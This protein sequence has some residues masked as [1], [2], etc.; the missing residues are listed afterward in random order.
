LSEDVAVPLEALQQLI[1]THADKAQDKLLKLLQSSQ[2]SLTGSGKQ[3]GD[4][5]SHLSELVGKAGKSPMD[6]LH[7]A[8]S[9]YLPYYPLHPP[10]GF[11][12]R[13]EA[14][15]GGQDG[16]S[17]QN[18]DVQLVLWIET[19]RLGPFK[20]TIAP[21]QQGLNNPTPSQSRW[22]VWVEHDPAAVSVLEVLQAQVSQSS[23]G[24]HMVG[25]IFLPRM[26]S[27]SPSSAASSTNHASESNPSPSS[28]KQSVD[29][30]PTGSVSGG[31]L[32]LAYLFIRVVFE[33]DNREE[34][35][36]QRAASI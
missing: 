35:T 20:I 8:M 31:L 14:T 15:E 30:Q 9:L 25:M 10:Q 16:E 19:I 32:C 28:R 36:R 1:Q 22:Q 21:G 29:I 24:E 34:L 17:G 4:L 5:M 6:A 13:F 26:A 2:M 33:L 3:M 27:V 7:T 23:G 11:T 18:N 12:M